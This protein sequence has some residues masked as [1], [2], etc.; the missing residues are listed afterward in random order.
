[1]GKYMAEGVPSGSCSYMLDKSAA[2]VANNFPGT[3]PNV[4]DTLL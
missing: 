2:I 3:V 4:A 1:M